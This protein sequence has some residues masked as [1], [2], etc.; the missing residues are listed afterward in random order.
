MVVAKPEDINRHLDALNEVIL[1]SEGLVGFPL[2]PLLDVLGE[3]GEALG[4]HSSYDVLY[5]TIVKV[6]SAREGELAGARLLLRRGSQHL[7]ADRPVEAVRLL[8]RGLARLFKHE[9]R[10]DLVKALSLCGAAYERLGLLWAARGTTLAA[11][12]VA[13]SDFWTYEEITMLQATCYRRMK[14]LELQLGRIPHILAWHN[15]DLAVRSNLVEQGYDEKRL[16]HGEVDF[17]G[18]L[19]ILILK[20]ELW[21]LKWISS[22]PEVLDG[23][24]LPVAADSLRYALGHPVELPPGLILNQA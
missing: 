13:T 5:E 6:A 9:S 12:S 15:L 16:A 22:L 21:E 24:Q 2:E 4:V 20:T 14:W 23:L 11:A 10:H 19:A 1:Q 8:G 7:E 3:I 18:I 17:G